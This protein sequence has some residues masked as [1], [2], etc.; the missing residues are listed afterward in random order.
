MGESFK[1]KCHI[2][3]VEN[4]NV[5]GYQT[6]FVYDDIHFFDENGTVSVS[7]S[8]DFQKGVKILILSRLESTD[9]QTVCNFP[10]RALDTIR[11][12]Q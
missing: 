11:K 7:T 9:N 12:N 1:Y 4:D 3:E 2:R 6:H 5:S 8:T 10:T